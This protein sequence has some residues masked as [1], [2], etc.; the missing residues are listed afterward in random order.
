MMKNRSAC[1]LSLGAFLAVF[2]SM[3]LELLS[4]LPANAQDQILPLKI[5]VGEKAPE[6]VLPSAD[7]KIVKLSDYAG[8]NV[9][10]DFYRGYW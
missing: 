1:A 6:F 10:M 7:G 5:H 4:P 3:G 8:H 9:L 2:L